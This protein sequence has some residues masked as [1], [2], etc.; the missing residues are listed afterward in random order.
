MRASVY[1]ATSLDGFIARENGGIDW[2]AATQ[3]ASGAEDYGYQAFM[4]SI[5]VLVMG[6]NT[7]EL[8]QT[9]AEW[10]YGDTP[11]VVL[12]SRAVTIPD[13]LRKTV[14]AMNGTTAQVMQ[15]LA[16]RGWRHAYVDGGRTIQGFL[17]AGAIQ[18][19]IIK[20]G[21]GT[22]II[23]F[24]KVER[25]FCTPRLQCDPSLRVVVARTCGKS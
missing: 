9:F 24:S 25:R 10:P 15:Q 21:D 23:S 1:I 17:N 5:D 3:A 13:R 16:A 11:V 12:S 19:L 18:E 2:L 7:F 22:A 6:R 8:A 4:A 20:C 14:E